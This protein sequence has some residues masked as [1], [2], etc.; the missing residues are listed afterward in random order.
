MSGNDAQAAQPSGRRSLARLVTGTISSQAV[1][2]GSSLI[3][4]RLYSPTTFGAFASILAI[5]TVLAA[6]MTFSYPA[7]IPLA[8]SHSDGR[9]LAWLAMFLA[10]CVAV[11]S[12]IALTYLALSGS[13]LL[14]YR[15]SWF[16]VAFIPLTALSLAMVSTLQLLSAR[17][18]MYS[19]IAR[20]TVTGALGQAG[21][22]VL[23]GVLGAG[24]AGL[25]TGFLA[26]RL[27]NLR[28]LAHRSG[29]GRPPTKS[30]MQSVGRANSAMPRWLMPTV[31]LN[32]MGTTAIA[33][34]IAHL[35]GVSTAGAFALA[36]QMLSVPAALLG[37]SVG[38]VLFPKFAHHDREGGIDPLQVKRY[39]RSLGVIA[40]PAFLPVF[41]VGPQLFSF[42]FGEDWVVAGEIAAVLA[43]WIA[44]NFI[45]GPLSS[46][47]VIKRRFRRVFL[48]GAIE[49]LARLGALGLGGVLH[50]EIVGFWLYSGVGVVICV[51][52]ITYALY[53]SGADVISLGR[54]LLPKGVCGLL[55]FVT[56]TALKVAAP[57]GVVLIVTIALLT[58]SL[59][60]ALKLLRT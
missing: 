18:G 3:L 55:G 43:P 10:S 32:L 15:I 53:L 16:G 23:L 48:V 24:A 8:K 29:L 49:S 33:P 26:G 50:S 60:P 9:V 52:S 1:Q 25:N 5:A 51:V 42:V 44:V 47:A 28:V 37:Q 11:G 31:V 38:A 36:M 35:F 46:L 20:A 14:G 2:L 7:A 58:M 17:L 57:T 21:S 22:Q 40:L 39:A 19:R 34:W 54:S 13:T 30:M 4:S 56:L 45:S 59:F 6:L 41:M 27:L 12:A